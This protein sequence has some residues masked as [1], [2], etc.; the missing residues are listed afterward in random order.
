MKNKEIADIFYGIADLLEI[1]EVDYKPRAYRRAARSIETMAEDIENIY[2]RDELQE[3]SGVGDAI[4][5]KIS[6]YLE[7]GRLEYYEELKD[8]LDI[9]IEGLISIEG[10]GPKSAKKLYEELDVKNLDDLEKAAKRDKIAKVEGFGKK[11]QQ[12]IIENI[13][14]AKKGQNRQLLGKIRPTVEKLRSKLQSIEIFKKVRIVGSY[15]RKKPTIGDIDVLALSGKPEEAMDIFC[16]LGEVEKVLARGETKSSIIISGGLQVDLRIVEEVSYGSALLYF[17]G[18]KEHNIALRNR[19]RSRDW[20]LNEYGLYDSNGETLAGE[21]E[22]EIYQK[23]GLSYIPPELRENTGEI[24]AS[25]KDSLPDLLKIK[26]IKGDFQIHTSYSDGANSVKE[27]ALEAENRGLDYI[28][29]SDHGPSLKI[30]DGMSREEFQEQKDEV[31]RV[32]NEM[33]PKVLQGIEANIT[34]DGL[35]VSKSW[36]EECD[37]LCAAVHNR[38]DNL[39]EKILSIFENYPVDIFVHPLGRKIFKRDSIDMDLDKIFDKAKEENIAIEINSQ[40]ER[41]DLDWRNVKKYRDRVKFVIS[42]DAH[43]RMEMGYMK[44]GVS[45]AR[46]GWCEKNNI[47]NT[48]PVDK[49]MS[50]FKD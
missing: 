41:L 30:A 40:P 2:E 28:L 33:G 38:L 50:Y 10:I 4:A 42:T 1:K 6:E 34:S 35:D 21:T 48:E 32:N 46:R 22:K 39:T 43:S 13:E 18:S 20:K 9:D 14:D 17:T 25:E 8:E 12:K 24:E 27:M 7:T 49:M 36:I 19:A 44:F 31:E 37:I 29:L 15:R 5:G 45:Q 3:I 47:L 16:G 11:T 23:F 26:D